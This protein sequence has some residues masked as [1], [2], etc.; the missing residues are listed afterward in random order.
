MLGNWS[1][2]DY[3]KKGA[4]DFAWEL[5]TQVYGLDP[6]RLWESVARIHCRYATYFEGSEAD[7]VECDTEAYEIWKTHLPED[8]ILKGNKKVWLFGGIDK[9]ITSGKWAKWVPVVRVFDVIISWYIGSE[10]HYD[11]IGGRNA[12]SLVNKD[13]PNVIEIWNLV[14]MQFSR[15]ASGTLHLLPAKHVDTGMGFE[16]ITSILQNKMSN[17]DTDIFSPIFEAI[18]QVA[19]VEGY[20]GLVAGQNG[21]DKM[22]EQAKKDMA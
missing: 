15:D 20:T 1:F 18:H 8:H 14:F 21:V 3:F 19:G 9:R 5:L 7:G 17:Y 4:I 10:I 13:D 12:A 16:R 2:G 6:S 22:N 11:R